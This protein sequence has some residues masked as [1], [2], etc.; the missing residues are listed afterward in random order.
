VVSGPLNQRELGIKAMFPF[1]IGVV[2]MQG[3]WRELVWD[4]RTT[5]EGARVARELSK[6]GENDTEAV[7]KK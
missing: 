7:G 5:F 4:A 3:L 2:D 1:Q 6:N